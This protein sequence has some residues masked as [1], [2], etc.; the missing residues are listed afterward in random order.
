MNKVKVVFTPSGIQGEVDKDTDIMTAANELGADIAT[1]CGGNGQCARCKIQI[2]SGEFAKHN[3]T[4]KVENLSDVTDIEIKRLSKSALEQGYRLACR[5]KILADIV[6][7]V[8]L[9]SQVHEQVIRKPATTLDSDFI[10]SAVSAIQLI[11]VQVEEPQLDSPT[12]DL[13][14]LKQAIESEVGLTK[15]SVEPALLPQLQNVLRKGNWQVTVAIYEQSKVIA[16]W[17]S[18]Q[19]TAYGLAVDIGSTTIVG[20][21]CDLETGEVLATHGLMNPQIRFGEDLMS[22]VSYSMMNPGGVQQMT[23]IV[24]QSICT[25]VDKLLSKSKVARDK[26]LDAVFVGNPV[27]HHLFLGIDPIELGGAP[28]ALATQGS[29]SL[30][31]S[32]LKLNLAEGAQ[33]YIPPCIAGHVGADAAAVLLAE[34]PYKQGKITLIIDVG[35]NAEI[36]LGNREK[37]VAAS[38]PT[39]PAFEGAQINDGQRAAPGAIERVRIDSETLEP[40]IKIIGVDCWSN[41][42]QFESALTKNRITGICGSGIIEAIASLFLV[43]IIKPDGVI[44]GDKSAISDRVIKNGKTWAYRLVDE[45]YGES[46]S[47]LITQNDVRAIQL[48]KATLYASIKLL[49]AKLKGKNIEKICFA[50]AFGAQIDPLYAMLLGMIP[51]CSLDNLVSV[52]NAAGTGARKALLC[53]KSRREIESEVIKLE[54][55]ETAVEANFQEHFI[56]AMAL[57]HKVDQFENLAKLVTIPQQLSESRSQGRG[58]NRR[59]RSS[60]GDRLKSS[61]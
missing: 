53:T 44:D 61:R 10:S 20:H 49:L 31:A 51:D 2:S 30:P 58:A 8:P 4:S 32:T 12:G 60:L 3:I 43:G 42:K 21:L 59:R 50:G 23:D 47:V 45:R 7:D 14:R 1:L 6:V 52:G 27:M 15:L 41:D 28:F 25:I 34:R 46:S 17:P 36:I 26:L 33:I 35:T 48:A 57:P 11:Y 5:A 55:I 18:K 22:R 19:L 13:E 39:G 54:K 29:V 38:S 24:R 16:I 56:N 37:L 40:T 9:D